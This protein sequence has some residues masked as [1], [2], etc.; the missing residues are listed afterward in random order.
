MNKCLAYDFET[1]SQDPIDGVVVSIAALQFDEG[2]FLTNP[3]SFSEMIS[4]ATSMKFDVK[5]QIS[6]YGR[7]VQDSTVSWWKEQEKSVRM[8]ILPSEEDVSIDRLYDFLVVKNNLADCKKVYTRNNSF[9]P[10]FVHSIFRQ[11]GKVNPMP[12][13]VVRDFKSTIMGLS[14]GSNIK[15]SFVPEEVKNEFRAH[16]PI[17]DVAMDVYRL[18][19][20]VRIINE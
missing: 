15:D 11:L 5:E 13:Y 4:L 20:L 19:Y 10:V 17:H 12:Y 16:D 9:D 8:A 7:K 1:L 18:Q 6:K 14:W 3:Y 2:R